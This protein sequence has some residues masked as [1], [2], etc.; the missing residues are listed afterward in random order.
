MKPTFPALIAS[1]AL[2]V[3]TSPADAHSRHHR[4]ATPMGVVL[5][6]N[7][8]AQP[9][10]VSLGGVAVRTLSAYSTETL[11]A[12]VGDAELR[13]TVQLYGRS[14]ELLERRVRISE[15]RTGFVQVEA[16]TVGRVKVVNDT[17]VPATAFVNGREVAELGVG[18]SKIVTVPLG[19]DEITMVANG[20]QVA[21]RCVTARPFTETSVVGE[22]PRFASVVVSN[23]LPI[24]VAVRVDGFAE[25]E[26]PARG[27]V[28]FAGVPVGGV[29]V[30][31]ERVA[32]GRLDTDRA[33]VSPWSG[34][35]LVVE[36]PRTGFVRLDSHDDDMVQVFVD[37]RFLTTVA[38]RGSFV[39]ELPVGDAA[40]SV[41][42]L[43]GRPVEFERIQVDPYRTLEVDFGRYED[44]QHR[45][46]EERH[47]GHDGRD[48]HDDRVST[49]DDGERHHEPAT[50]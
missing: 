28:S 26:V 30:T 45:R 3:A 2:A 6:Q 21:E 7:T 47:D 34:A 38:P 31:T 11:L 19:K 33:Y 1:L 18:A 43:D 20:V 27:S 46:G 44:G 8:T 24:P 23:P 42:R 15:R 16:P 10:T 36:P 13:A 12:P 41:T 25:R 32:G 39:A 48:R 9:I 35:F 29:T 17:G 37:G 5:V 14:F 4:P 40:V 49:R 22:A 50:W